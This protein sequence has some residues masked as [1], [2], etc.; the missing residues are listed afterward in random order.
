[1]RI[2]AGKISVPFVTEKT[3]LDPIADKKVTYKYEYLWDNN[4]K[5]GFD[6]TSNTP[7]VNRFVITLPE[8]NGKIEKE[9]CSVFLPGG[10]IGLGAGQTCKEYTKD[11]SGKI[12]TSMESHYQ[13]LRDA[14]W[15]K[16]I[17][18]DVVDSKTTK[19]NNVSTR[20]SLSYNTKNGQANKVIT[21]VNNSP[22][23]EKN[24][25]YAYEVDAYKNAMLASNRIAEEAGYYVCQRKCDD[26][27]GRIV[28]ANASKY[29]NESGK[30]V[31]SEVW[32]YESE[33]FDKTF[34]FDYTSNQQNSKWKKTTEYSR[35]IDGR[36]VET[37]DRLKRKSSAFYEN[38]KGG[39]LFGSVVGAGIDEARLHP[40]NT[41]EISGWTNCK[42]T[43][44]KNGYAVNGNGV[45]FGRFDTRAIQLSV[46]SDLETRIPA[47]RNGNYRFSAWIQNVDDVDRSVQLFVNGSVKN[48]WTLQ[49]HKLWNYVEFETP[50]GNGSYRIA[51]RL[52]DGSSVNL[53]D[54]R[55]VPTIAQ[56]SVTFWNK[57]WSK[58]NVQVND[59][60]IGE[61]VVY[62][63]RGRIVENWT[64]LEDGSV[65][66]SSKKEYISGACLVEPNGADGLK[67]LSINGENLD[68]SDNGAELYY[69]ISDDVTELNV[70]WVT[71]QDKD[72]VYYQYYA[73]NEVT[74]DWFVS[75]CSD[76]KGVDISVDGIDN[77]TLKVDVAPQK[78]KIYT[79]HVN[80]IRS[81][82]VKYGSTL[83]VGSK[84]SFLDDKDTTTLSYLSKDGFHTAVYDGNEWNDSVKLYERI[85]QFVSTSNG[86]NTF[87]FADQDLAVGRRT[88]ANKTGVLYS[89]SSDVWSYL[90]NVDTV[91]VKT[92]KY[93]TAIDSNNVL[94]LLYEKNVSSYSDRKWNVKRNQWD[95]SYTTSSRLFVKQYSNH[96]W[97]NV[98]GSVYVNES[99]NTYGYVE[100]AVS[101]GHV[102]DADIIIGPN[103]IPYVAYIG[104]IEMAN[105]DTSETVIAADG[106]D[107]TIAKTISPKFVV[108]KRLYNSSEAHTLKNERV[109]AG[110]TL[111]QEPG[112]SDYLPDYS[113][114]LLMVGDEPLTGAKKL[115]FSS[116][117]KN[118]YLAVSYDFSSNHLSEKALSVF[119]FVESATPIKVT[120]SYEDGS[121]ESFMVKKASFVPYE[122]NS[123]KT[124]FLSNSA[125]EERKIIAYLSD[126]C[127]FDFVVKDTVP[128]VAFVSSANYN[129]LTVVKY[130]KGRWVSVGKPAFAN[131][132]SEF[133]SFD[134]SVGLHTPVLVF[135]E[136]GNSSRKS[137]DH[138]V[139][140]KY[141]AGGDLN[142]TIS[143]VGSVKGTNIGGI[144][145]Q[146]LLN[147]SA[148]MDETYQTIDFN[149]VPSNKDD[150][151]HIQIENNDIVVDKIIYSD[152]SAKKYS[153]FNWGDLA[154]KSQNR[155]IRVS[156]KSG[157]NKIRI[158]VCGKNGDRLAYFFDITSNQSE[159]SDFSATNSNGGVAVKTKD[160][161]RYNTD[162]LYIR[163]DTLIV[164]KPNDNPTIIPSSVKDTIIAKVTK[165]TELVLQGD[166][167]VQ[168]ACFG[169]SSDW[170]MVHCGMLYVRATCFDI[171]IGSTR[172]N[173]CTPGEVN[174][175]DTIYVVN[176][177]NGETE[178]VVV[179]A[180]TTRI[181][182]P[183]LIVNDTIPSDNPSSSSSVADSTASSS[184]SST[185]HENL[186]AVPEE[187]ATLLNQKLVAMGSLVLADRAEIRNGNYV[188]DFVEVGANASVHG[189]LVST[190]NMVLRNSAKVDTVVVNG[191]M[192]KQDNV[193]LD[194]YSKENVEKPVIPQLNINVGSDNIYAGTG[195]TTVVAPGAYKTLQAYAGSTV[196]LNPGIYYFDEFSIEP[197]SKV[198]FNNEEG[199]IQLWVN[200]RI[201]FADRVSMTTKKSE[202]DMFIYTNS[203]N[204]LYLGVL[205]EIKATV[206][207][208]NCSVN[209]AP[210]SRWN[211]LIWAK[212]IMIN[213]D[214]VVE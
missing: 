177:K 154:S 157:S 51:F 163:V 162:S 79:V 72:K 48:T 211:G 13:R 28:E 4:N 21:Y 58:P 82:W 106:K 20:T 32:K 137:R 178:V 45:G 189:T 108:V 91:G 81:G 111:S 193:V 122:D 149:I 186:G 145:R 198:I 36:A 65:V 56:S 208:P 9:L 182:P 8:S 181:K 202:R 27:F 53:Q 104:S 14:N 168:N 11:A 60:G 166:S 47:A 201:Y 94:Y 100:G 124:A 158:V 101:D 92:E 138:I 113:G 140:M 126:N 169:F 19:A 46:G 62:D 31:V 102:N 99:S 165:E 15:P 130:D 190:G 125:S 5:V 63:S 164:T 180:D 98:G 55:I 6:Y 67:K 115:K 30:M 52:V 139:P 161:I 40:G 44:L 196:I 7:L 61:Y 89:Y 156:L 170:D 146:Y 171:K 109:W 1:M 25:I 155:P 57:K 64:E 184:D 103:G 200:R 183:T 129:K 29:K 152:E 24:V 33:N 188:A 136:K 212:Q 203:T 195:K 71:K 73:G 199:P 34:S 12:V 134:L 120:E 26:V 88:N 95:S 39:L 141:D 128:Y 131:P 213:A 41:C 68:I 97:K 59:R 83:D 176:Q 127:D 86:K 70:S 117:G 205:S 147:Y 116:N 148:V 197:D 54:I 10:N 187:F 150:L 159:S 105:K 85:N 144:F 151:S 192:S 132:K 77:L 18:Q 42:L 37:I 112:T 194:S 214:A 69:S 207:A 90:G 209:I 119:K 23:S 175:G 153:F 17:Y 118:I 114:D 172:K 22:I 3:I 143:S 80:R 135:N 78:S 121:V 43:D 74:T 93:K 16:R 50:L 210:N 49:K 185:N 133:G 75:C 2:R 35:Y 204:D 160:N 206:V 179:D 123:V 66:L 87:M 84:P 173:S 107:S 142:L 38:G 174:V 96:S 167:N 191:N 76:L 110:T